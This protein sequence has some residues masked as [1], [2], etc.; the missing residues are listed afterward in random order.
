MAG[1]TSPSIL[2]LNTWDAPEREY[3]YRLL[4]A[5]RQNGYDKLVE[6]YAGGFANPIVAIEA[7]WK[8]EQI[9]TVD[10]WLYTAILGYLY[11]GR[12]LHELGMKI[13]GKPIPLDGTPV[14]QAARMILAQY[15]ARL[16]KTAHIEYIDELLNDVTLDNS[17]QMD[18]LCGKLTANC[19]RLN[20][21]NHIVTDSSTYLDSILD[22]PNTLIMANPPTY[23]GAYE[24][25][26]HQLLDNLTSVDDMLLTGLDDSQFAAMD[27]STTVNLNSINMKYAFKTVELTFLSKEFDEFKQFVEKTTA[28]MTVIANNSLYQQFSEEIITYANRHNIKNVNAAIS[29]IIEY[30]QKDAEET[31]EKDKK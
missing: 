22:Q 24:K 31:A 21:I 13:D 28:D 25:T 15:Q 16:E 17:H 14:H 9:T 23:R 11:S 3:N 30:C 8:P 2:F 4:S 18:Y 1:F 6:L 10:V 29:R 12:P 27:D 5:A 7:G 19:Q 20:G 26:L